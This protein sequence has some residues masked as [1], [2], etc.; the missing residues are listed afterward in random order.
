[1]IAATI[2]GAISTDE[3]DRDVPFPVSIFACIYVGAPAG[4]GVG[5]VAGL[6]V[7]GVFLLIEKAS[8][9]LDKRRN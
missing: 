5:Y 1:M 6:L 4:A 8:R 9:R 3:Y 2:H 7:A